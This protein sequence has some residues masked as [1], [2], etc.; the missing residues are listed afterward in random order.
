MCVNGNGNGRIV[1][2]ALVADES[3]DTVKKVLSFFRESSVAASE[4]LRTIVIDKDFDEIRS[5]MRVPVILFVNDTLPVDVTK[6]DIEQN[7]EFGEL[8]LA[9]SSHVIDTGVSSQIQKDLVQAEAELRHEKH[10]WL[11]QRL[12]YHELQE[13]LLDY[14]LKG[15]EVSLASE[16]RQFHKILQQCLTMAEIEDYLDFSPDPSSKVRLLGLSTEELQHQNP[17]RKH[18]QYIQQKLIPEVEDRLRKKS[19]NFVNF[20]EPHNTSDSSNLIFAKANQLPSLVESD[21]R[22][23]VEEKR[24]YKNDRSRSN[25]Q[26]WLYYQTLVDSLN[27]LERLISQHRL[28]KQANNDCITSE[29][30]IAR[31][32]AMCLKIKLL[33]LNIL[34]DTY[35]AETV[36]AL[37]IVRKQLDSKLHEGHKERT[38]LRQALQAY[39]AVGMGF[40]SLVEEYGQLCEELENKQWAMSELEQ[41]DS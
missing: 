13:L 20:H 11:L 28:D 32:D 24:Q 41:K 19:E 5:S 15:Q 25:K 31:C 33:E 22:K 1:A 26:F 4:S 12:L 18:L 10:T 27:L 40:D 34:C 9:L 30:M 17:Y 6:K 35:S 7:P 37:R 23:L 2:Y 8:L 3:L 36:Q 39:E 29:W 16:D 38:N 21:Q 14:D